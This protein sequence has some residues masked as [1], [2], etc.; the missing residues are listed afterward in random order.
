MPIITVKPVSDTITEVSGR[1]D[2]DVLTTSAVHELATA[3]TSFR[4]PHCDADHPLAFL[5]E[6]DDVTGHESSISI[7][8]QEEAWAI[9]AFL[10]VE[11]F[12]CVEPGTWLAMRTMAEI[13]GDTDHPAMN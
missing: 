3:V 11:A 2:L 1:V 4:C 6:R 7:R 5:A 9:A 13:D 10:L 8:D 12:G